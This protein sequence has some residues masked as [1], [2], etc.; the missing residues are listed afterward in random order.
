[1][2]SH[3]PPWTGGGTDM[4]TPGHGGMLIGARPLTATELESSPT[5]VKKREGSIGV[6]F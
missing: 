6:P 1:L 2:G 5:G 4:G 3:G